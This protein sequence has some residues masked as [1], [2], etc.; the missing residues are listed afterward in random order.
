[1]SELELFVTGLRGES[2]IE[3][4]KC[5]SVNLVNKYLFSYCHNERSNWKYENE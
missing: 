2:C 3:I 5:D 4:C 1:M